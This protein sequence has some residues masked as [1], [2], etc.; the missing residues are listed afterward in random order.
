MKNGNCALC[1]KNRE[2]CNSHIIPRA[3]LKKV[4]NHNGK[5]TAVNPA[6]NSARFDQ[7]NYSEYLLCIAC[8]QIIKE[9][10]DY[11]VPFFR[12]NNNIDFRDDCV[13]CKDI[14][15]SPLQLYLTSL[16]WRASVS[17]I[18]EKIELPQELEEECRISL[19]NQEPLDVLRCLITKITDS[20]KHGGQ[21]KF[22]NPE[23]FITTPFYVNE[24]LCFVMQGFMFEF[25][26]LKKN[27]T[28][29][30]TKDKEQIFLYTLFDDIPNIDMIKEAWNNPQGKLIDFKKQYNN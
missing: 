26:S 22:K 19:L 5:F 1:K 21:G 25:V 15:Y 28:G 16:V 4:A 8:E 3:I 29:L 24:R 12:N 30:L 2:L 11:G 18:F 9:Y 20:K 27:T 7:P 6:K 14:K 13:V 17:S 10:E 23:E